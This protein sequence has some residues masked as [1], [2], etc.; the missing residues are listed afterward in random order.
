MSRPRSDRVGP[1]H[2]ALAGVV[3]D[4][5]EDDADAGLPQ[6]RDGVAQVGDAARREARV[7][8][9]EGDRIVAPGIGEAERPEVALV[10]PGRDRHQFDGI[11]AETLQMIDD[12]RVRQRRHGA[13]LLLRHD[14]MEHGEG[15]DLELVD[16]AAGLEHGR[17]R[18]D[19][20]QQRFDDGLGHQRRGVGPLPARGA[21]RWIIA[22]GSV[23]PRG[24]GV[25]QEF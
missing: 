18:R 16:E 2:V 11:D 21:E 22:I 6:R 1:K 20:G 12:R 9:H 7:E 3:E 13:A 17:Q 4:E 24:I 15:A 14:R 10:D 25:H 23:D 19:R 5:V 8:R